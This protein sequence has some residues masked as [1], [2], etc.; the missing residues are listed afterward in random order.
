M[1]TGPS[2][3]QTV[4]GT[5]TQAPKRIT[6]HRAA[7]NGSTSSDHLIHLPQA[8]RGTTPNLLRAA[9]AAVGVLAVIAA[10]VLTGAASGAL[11]QI[12]T[13][14]DTDAPSVRATNDF[15]FKLQ[16]MDAQ[17]VNM[18]LVNGDTSVH[19]PRAKSEVLYDQDRQDANADLEAATVALAGNADALAKL[20]DVTD[21]FGQYQ[22][23]AA[24]TVADDEREGTDVAGAAP[25]TVFNEYIAG[26]DLLFGSDGKGGL[27]AAA[28]ALEQ[29]SK[30]AINSSADSADSALTTVVVGFVIFGVMLVG[31]LVGLQFL[32]FRRFH[33]VVNPALAGATVVAL[34]LLIGGAVG[35]GSAAGDFHTAKSSAFDSVLALGEANATSAGINSDESRWLLAHAEPGERDKFEQSFGQ[36]ETAVADV[37]GNGSLAAYATALHQEAEQRTPDNL[38]QTSM[39]ANSSFGEEF[40]NITFPGESEAAQAAFT[41]FDAYI[42]DDQTLRAMPLDT[43]AHLKAAIDFDTNADT[44]GTSDQAFNAYSKALGDVISLNEAQFKSSL[45][46]AK[47]GIG[48]WTW[49]PY[50][51]TVLLIGLAVLGLRP[52]L[53]E[54]R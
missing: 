25:G 8:P 2:Y 30:Q 51:L 35:A 31:G 21:A 19:V 37:A 36:G 13:V 45:P 33:R 46:A 34:V 3:V 38:D 42:Q 22:A 47:D 43:S 40:H 29:T 9:V 53:N 27:M 10:V 50:V 26:Y 1:D 20:H 6:P 49:L 41:A 14:G 5:L 48:T 32:L 16:D 28:E 15:L 11:S 44:P 39:T 4:S 52:R 17:L 23:Q 7:S 18:L 54:Y 12:S 24:R